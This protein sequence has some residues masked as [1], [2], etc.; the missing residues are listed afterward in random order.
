MQPIAP[1]CPHCI[2]CLIWNMTKMSSASLG[3][4]L[5]SVLLEDFTLWQKEE[6]YR[7]TVIYSAIPWQMGCIWFID[8]LFLRKSSWEF[9]D[10]TDKLCCP[11]FPPSP[12]SAPQLS[13][14][15]CWYLEFSLLLLNWNP[16]GSQYVILTGSKAFKHGIQTFWFVSRGDDFLLN[17]INPTYPVWN[18]INTSDNGRK[19]CSVNE[20]EPI[21]HSEKCLLLIRS[22]EMCE[23]QSPGALMSWGRRWRRWSLLG[24]AGEPDLGA[25]PPSELMSLCLGMVPASAPSL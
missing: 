15:T 1:C 12:V 18:L 9:S 21:F 20:I 2:S 8:H 17:D 10:L 5:F 24:G 13:T 7:R 16:R 3:C 14:R 4:Y 6:C 25:G 22:P 19:C 11:H 23:G